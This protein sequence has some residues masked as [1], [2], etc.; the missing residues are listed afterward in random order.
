MECNDVV[1]ILLLRFISEVTKNLDLSGDAADRAAGDGPRHKPT[2]GIPEN[3]SVRL[4]LETAT[5]GIE[6]NGVEVDVPKDA[7]NEDEP[8]WELISRQREASRLESV[9]DACHALEADD[10]VEILVNSRLAPQQ[11]IHAPASVSPGID[12]GRL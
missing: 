4:R 1:N 9:L 2:R 3:L 12:A 7:V 8:D 10:K 11:G 5:F 6:R